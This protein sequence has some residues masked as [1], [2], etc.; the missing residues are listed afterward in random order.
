M[1]AVLPHGKMVL[2]LTQVFC[3]PTM[4]C[5]VNHRA[6]WRFQPP[7]ATGASSDSQIASPSGPC[8]GRCSSA[9]GMLTPF[10]TCSA[11]AG[12]HGVDRI[13][14]D[15]VKCVTSR[16]TTDPVPTGWRSDAAAASTSAAAREPPVSD[17][18]RSLRNTE[19]GHSGWHYDCQS[20]SVG[21]DSRSTRA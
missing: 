2:A 4:A 11:I 6:A 14:S 7:G 16:R 17:P 15:T 20:V 21:N 13:K 9:L 5:N 12:A 3:Y 18:L 1:R 10:P 19:I 8:N